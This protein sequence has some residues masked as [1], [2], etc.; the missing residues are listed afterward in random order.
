MGEAVESKQYAVFHFDLLTFQVVGSLD[1]SRVVQQSSQQT[2]SA[3]HGGI[4]Q[5][6]GPEQSDRHVQMIIAAA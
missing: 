6:Q 5:G 3:P 2:I 4:Q 1:P